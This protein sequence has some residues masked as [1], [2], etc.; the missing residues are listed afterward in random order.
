V[1]K[2]GIIYHW[3]V[4]ILL[5]SLFGF[6]SLHK[7]V[8]PVPFAGLIAKNDYVP[9]PLI[10]PLSIWLPCFEIALALCLLLPKVQKAALILAAFLLAFFAAII[11]LNL[12][13][14]LEVPCGCFSNQ[15]QPATWW[16]VGRNL[17]LIFLATMAV[18]LK[19]KKSLLKN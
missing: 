15:N 4:C 19:K 8:D 7:I 11:A 5:A 10:G 17:F 3:G 12:L 16:S 6:A 18:F 13:R 9:S 14:G 1:R 2:L